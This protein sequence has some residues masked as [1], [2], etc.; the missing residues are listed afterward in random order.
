L[1]RSEIRI[2]LGLNFNDSIRF[3]L[4]DLGGVCGVSNAA[5]IRIHPVAI[6]LNMARIA[7]Y[8]PESKRQGSEP[9]AFQNGGQN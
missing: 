6:R 4:A 2:C 9:E 8:W 5:I 7:C 1:I 3:L